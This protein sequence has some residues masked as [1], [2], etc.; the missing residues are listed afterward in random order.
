M[1]ELKKFCREEELASGPKQDN[2]LSPA[3]PWT[4]PGLAKDGIHGKRGRKIQ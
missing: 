1:D 4:P 3:P 2:F